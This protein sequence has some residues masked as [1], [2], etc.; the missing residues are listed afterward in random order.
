MRKNNIDFTTLQAEPGKNK[1]SLCTPGFL[2]MCA[3]SFLI[4]MSVYMLVPFLPLLISGQAEVS[5]SVATSVVAVLLVCMFLVGPLHAYLGDTYKRKSVWIYS[6][7]GMLVA[8]AG[9]TLVRTSTE[10][11]A[12]LAIYGACFGLFMTAGITIT[13]D[14]IPSSRRSHGNMVYALLSRLGMLVG[15][16]AGLY[17]YLAYTP[18]LLVYTSVACGLLGLFLVLRVHVAFRAPI[19]LPVFSLDRFLLPRAWIPALNLLCLSLAAGILIPTLWARCYWALAGLAVVAVLIVPFTKIFVKLS[20]HCQ[21][22]TANTTCHLAVETGL[23]TGMAIAACMPLDVAALSE[24][25]GGMGLF[26]L[27]F[28][29][30]ITRP[31]F[32][33]MR[34]R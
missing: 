28:Y 33:K 24:L 1:V 9:F 34:V 26:S 21:R 7:L 10:W 6:V 14:I 30:L 15:V 5:V 23:W 31:Y 12:L 16:A 18:H 17:V 2:H 32:R 20:H 13:I 22:G 4:M 3:G 27:I 11:L 25:A 29:L 19:G 8:S